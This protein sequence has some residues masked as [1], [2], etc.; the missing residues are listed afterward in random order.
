MYGAIEY[1]HDLL[2]EDIFE[3]AN[4]AIVEGSTLHGRMRRRLT[5]NQRSKITSRPLSALLRG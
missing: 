3:A 2:A 1:E 4:E 5:P